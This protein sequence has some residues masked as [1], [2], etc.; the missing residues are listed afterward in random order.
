MMVV[1]RSEPEVTYA[2]A[3]KTGTTTNIA[4][5]TNRIEELLVK[6][7]NQNETMMQLL[8]TVILKLVK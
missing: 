1:H 7:I 2:E 5:S 8:Q 3:T 6:L 4:T